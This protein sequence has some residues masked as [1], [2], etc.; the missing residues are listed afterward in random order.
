MIDSF[1]N[2]QTVMKD[3][4]D[5]TLDLKDKRESHLPSTRHERKGES[6]QWN[7]A[8]SQKEE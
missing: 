7:F 2:N 1:I 5:I 4:F 6:C 3:R 8:L